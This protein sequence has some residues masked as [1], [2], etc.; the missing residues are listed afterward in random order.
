MV[1]CFVD[2]GFICCVFLCFVLLVSLRV[3]LCG[4]AVDV[5]LFF[6]C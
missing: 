3:C 6:V 1:Y 2:L 4:A 5:F